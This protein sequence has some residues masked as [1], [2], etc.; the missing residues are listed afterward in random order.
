M[1]ASLMHETGHSKLVLWENPEEWG[2]EADVRGIQD[3]ES[4]V[5]LWMI[6]ASV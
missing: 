4:C 5:H 2:G 1:S 3:E 6:C